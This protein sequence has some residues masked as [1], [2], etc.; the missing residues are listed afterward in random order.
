MGLSARPCELPLVPPCDSDSARHRGL[1]PLRT[2]NLTLGVKFRGSQV[3]YSGPRP[4]WAG[5]PLEPLRTRNLTL[6]V[7]FRG[8]QVNYSGP[9]PRWAGGPLEFQANFDLRDTRVVHLRTHP[10]EIGVGDI[11]LDP[12]EDDS[13]EDVEDVETDPELR[14]ADAKIAPDAEVLVEGARISQIEG[15]RARRVAVGERCRR[16]EGGAID[17]RGRI[18]GEHVAIPVLGVDPDRAAERRV[19]VRIA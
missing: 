12:A 13:V 2:R 3:N 19:E 18:R 5:G 15:E 17:V 7:K 14:R 4:R 9:R 16:L 8:S 6:G 11:G 10:A 1:E